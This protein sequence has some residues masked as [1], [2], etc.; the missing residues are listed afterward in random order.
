MQQKW[1]C[2]H[3]N[4]LDEFTINAP[5]VWCEVCGMMFKGSILFKWL[6]N[7][8]DSSFI[9]FDDLMEL[10]RKV[11][12]LDDDVSNLKRDVKGDSYY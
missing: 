6:E 2:G 11:S 12:A 4:N 9:C 5:Y 1:P 7:H 8:L 10:S 3:S